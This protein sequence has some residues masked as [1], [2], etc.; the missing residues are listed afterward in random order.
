MFTGLIQGVGKLLARETRGGDARLRI[1]FGALETGDVVPGE[2]IAVNGVCLTVVAFDAASFDAD[3]S[4]ETLALTTLSNWAEGRRVNL[5]RAARVGDE[6]GG[7]IVSGHV[8][9]VGEVLSVESEGGS[10]RV[11]IRAPRPLHR[12]IAPKG[13][14]TVEGVSLTVNEVEDDVFGVNLI[15]HTWD[16]TTLGDLKAGSRVN[17][18]ID[19]LARYLARWRETA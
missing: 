4:N 1:G 10:H 6:L 17:L 7:H 16:V 15:P 18:E 2:S 19:M 14:I 11:R 13:S 9:G 12:F 3:A 5:E 8:D